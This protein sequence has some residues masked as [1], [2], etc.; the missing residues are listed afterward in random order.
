MITTSENMT[1]EKANEIEQFSLAV[2]RNLCGQVDHISNLEIYEICQMA[3]LLNMFD[4]N[5]RE[6]L[7]EYLGIIQA[8]WNIDFVNFDDAADFILYKKNKYE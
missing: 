7:I 1:L 2:K 8:Y 6:L 4:K 5:K 3:H